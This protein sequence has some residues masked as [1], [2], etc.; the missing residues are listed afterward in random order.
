MDAVVFLQGA[1]ANGGKDVGRVSYFGD[2]LQ[3]RPPKKPGLKQIIV[4]WYFTGES[5]HSRVSVVRNGFRSH[6]QYVCLFADL[7]VT[8]WAGLK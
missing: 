4:G 8:I 3:F 1:S 5:N 7:N 2:E 6:P